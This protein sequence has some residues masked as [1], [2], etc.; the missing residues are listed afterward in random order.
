M[1]IKQIRNATLKIKYGN[2]CFLIDPWFEE[3]GIG[4]NDVRKF[5]KEKGLKQI[6]VPEDDE[7]FRYL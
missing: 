3:Q 5:A 4:R 2:V 7:T 6:I 1:E